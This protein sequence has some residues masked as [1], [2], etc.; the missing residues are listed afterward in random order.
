MAFLLTVLYV[1]LVLLS[2]AALPE[3]LAGSH[4][5]EILAAILILCVLPSVSKAKLGSLP[6]TYLAFGFLGACLLSTIA[7]GWIGG[8]VYTFMGLLPTFIS[9]FFIVITCTTLKHLKILVYGLTLV[10]FFIIL[11]G[12][13]A[14]HSGDFTSKYLYKEGVEGSW[15][16]RY[17]GLGMIA[18]PN[19]FAQVLVTLIP[20]LWLR[21]EKGGYIGN[22]L[23]TLIPAFILLVGVYHTHSRG[24]ILALIAVLLYGL[25]D[26]LGIIGSSVIAGIGAAG[27]LVLNVSGGRGIGNDDGERVGL[28]AEGLQAFKMHFLFGIGNGRYVDITTVH[29]TAHNSFVLCL[30]ELGLLGYFFWTG[31]ITTSW[32]YLLR[33]IRSNEAPAKQSDE[34]SREPHRL[35]A[36]RAAYFATPQPV[37]AIAGAGGTSVRMELASSHGENSSPWASL[38][39]HYAP[40]EEKKGQDVPQL[41]QA[42]RLVQIAFVGFLVTG[43]F[44][45]RTYIITLY[46]ILGMSASLVR[47]SPTPI[48]VRVPTLIRWIL[49]VMF[50]SILVI[51]LGIRLHGGH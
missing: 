15:L 46:V 39:Q 28:W 25:K 16:Y 30:V 48:S 18:D 19:D 50:G 32:I 9:F 5:M 11:Q 45:S 12:A 10:C 43:F 24:A 40:L 13:L 3:A 27:M 20:L 33:L 35:Q 23:L 38:M 51:Y 2:P 6:Q 49:L 21:W 22:V 31:W 17:R 8:A 37:E 34:E 14:D 1:M 26:K 36:V 42:A 29:K 47:M 7:T 44:I 4:I 41:V